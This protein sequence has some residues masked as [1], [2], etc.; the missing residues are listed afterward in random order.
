MPWS[1][2]VC[3]VIN[4]VDSWLACGVCGSPRDSAPAS[5][6]A[7]VPEVSPSASAPEAA[8]AP[9]AAAASA[10]EVIV[11]DDDGAGASDQASSSGRRGE[12]SAPP[13]T[14]PAPKRQGA[15]ASA[16]GGAAARRDG[17]DDVRGARA[18][19]DG[20]QPPWGDET[21][22][23]A[24]GDASRCAAL[25]KR[26]GVVVFRGVVPADDRS[27]L[28]S[29]FWDWLERE[30]EGVDRARP[31]THAP[32]VFDSLGHRNSGVVNTGSI[33]QSDLLWAERQHA[34]VVDAWRTVWGLD[35]TEPAATTRQL[36]TSFD[37]CGV[38]RN[39]CHPAHAG[40]ANVRT[41]QSWYHLGALTVWGAD[42]HT[43][44][45]VVW[46]G[47]HKQFAE[48]CARGGKAG[49]GS[50]VRMAGRGDAEYC[51]R[52]ARQVAPLGPGDYVIWDSR[53]VHCSNGASRNLAPHHARRRAVRHGATSG[54]D[55]LRMRSGAVSRRHAP[56]P[57]DSPIFRL[58]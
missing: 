7:S 17:V 2:A 38:W 1:C 23:C 9:E 36:V 27:R 34:G 58:V 26:F 13:A 50:F 55:P 30:H 43:G 14:A 19:A 54:H 39:P 49:R 15:S 11:V 5:I 10:P 41:A 12:A 4:D 35:M 18:A 37:G 51:A 32:R 3:T 56:P 40:K 22:V 8:D 21:P 24:I 42:G 16:P 45:T 20:R 46:P 33:G 57:D 52:T 31:A 6:G 29:L 53:V 48:N 47:S 44:S 25:L 28:E